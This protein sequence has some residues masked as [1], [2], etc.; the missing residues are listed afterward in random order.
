V[1]SELEACSFRNRTPEET[2]TYMSPLLEKHLPLHSNTSRSSTLQDERKKD[3]YSHF[4]LRLAFSSSEDSRRRFSRLETA[5]FKLRFRDD[6]VRERQAFVDSL[7]FEW[8]RVGAKEKEELGKDLRNGT[9]MSGKWGDEAEWF[10]VDWERVPELV[11]RRAVLLRRGTAY[12]PLREQ[13]SLVVAKFTR[14][15]D[16]ALE[17]RTFVA[18]IVFC[19]R[20]LLPGSGLL[21]DFGC[22]HAAQERC[23]DN[24]EEGSIAG[25]EW[26]R[27]RLP[28]V[29]A[30]ESALF[31]QHRLTTCSS[32]PARFHASTKMI[33]LL[34]YLPTSPNLS[35]R[36]TAHTRLQNR[37]LAIY[38]RMLAISMRYR[39]TF[40]CAC[41]TCTQH[42]R[43]IR[44]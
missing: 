27:N 36:Q 33:A 12:V 23:A 4:I 21:D 29:A 17:V 42:C 41:R 13:S 11:E 2:A 30:V 24:C 10:K 19:F 35:H 39:N 43:K 31:Y 40:H 18:F 6:D 15:L 38:N 7:D 22:G 34:P 1:L 16:H 8:E 9:G 37:F 20:F 5:L 28:F 25:T 3:H 14:R 32:P 26:F 44:I